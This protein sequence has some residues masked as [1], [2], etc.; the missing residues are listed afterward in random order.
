MQLKIQHK[1]GNF[2]PW[3]PVQLSANSQQRKYQG[4]RSQH[5][6]GSL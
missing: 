2:R 5:L 3:R 1:T 6:G 4:F